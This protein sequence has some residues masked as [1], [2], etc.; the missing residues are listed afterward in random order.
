M[1]KIMVFIGIEILIPKI[2]KSQLLKATLEIW[3]IQNQFLAASL[4]R[5]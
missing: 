1:I 5:L 4:H 3:L 2:N